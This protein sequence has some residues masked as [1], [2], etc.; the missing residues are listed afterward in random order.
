[1]PGTEKNPAF[2]VTVRV[3]GMPR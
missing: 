3:D 2:S 1:V